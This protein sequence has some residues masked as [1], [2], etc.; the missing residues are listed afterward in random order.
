M[1]Y[2][3]RR[4]TYLLTYFRF[5]MMDGRHIGILLAISI[6]TYSACPDASAFEISDE[7]RRTSDVISIYQDGGHRVGNILLSSGLVT[8][9]VQ[10]GENLCAYQIW[11]RYLNLLLR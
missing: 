8:A 7:H 5:R 3:N 4:F 10:N 1:R 2:I 6:L 11:M 9:F